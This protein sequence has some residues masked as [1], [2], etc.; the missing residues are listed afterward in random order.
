MYGFRP[1]SLL[2]LVLACG[3]LSAC[4][5]DPGTPRTGTIV[6][7]PEPN[8]L[9][10]PW[11][12][13]GPAGYLLAASGD[14]TLTGLDPG[15]YTVTWGAVTGYLTPDPESATL[16]GNQ[17]LTLAA[18]YAPAGPPAGFPDTP[19]Q[20]MTNFRGAY[21]QMDVDKLMTM[22]HPQHLTYL[23]QDTVDNFPELGPTLDVQEEQRIHER[24]F[25]GHDV[26]DPNGY[27][28][29]GVQ[30][31]TFQTFQ[32]QGNW[33]VSPAGDTIP[34]TE[35]ALYDVVI[36]MDRG[37]GHTI[38]KVQGAIKFYAVAHDSL[39]GGQTL[40]CYRLRGQVDL[41]VEKVS[42]TTSWGLVKGLFR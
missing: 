25:S 29:P 26:T 32:R 20:L 7:D 16:A 13:A 23:Q 3:F 6:L 9:S 34:N 28:V 4:N 27:L 5:D 2:A 33:S 38:L 36:L 35:F 18:T 24:M 11:Q 41:T 40:P 19:D 15:G 17:S 39:V 42:E 37:M 12:L 30:A 21:G 31:I 1:M 14:T 22:L 8:A 10:A